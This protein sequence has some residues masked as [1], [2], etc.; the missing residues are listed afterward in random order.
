[1]D[2]NCIKPEYKNRPLYDKWVLWVHLPHDTNWSLKSYK[3]I[4]EINTIVIR[5]FRFSFM[6]N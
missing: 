2:S 6:I 3:K 5:A 1:M 4:M